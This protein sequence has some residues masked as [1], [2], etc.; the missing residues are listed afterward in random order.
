MNQNLHESAFPSP[1]LESPKRFS[2]G[3]TW[4]EFAVVRQLRFEQI[5]KLLTR[6]T[7]G[8]WE[9][10]PTDH[11]VQNE[12]ALQNDGTILSEFKE[13]SKCENQEVKVKIET[14]IGCR[15]TKVRIA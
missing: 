2:Q 6:H 14:N 15:T 9:H 7:S 4:L 10:L 3:E 1:K 13:F 12:E 11:Q 5:C 8:D